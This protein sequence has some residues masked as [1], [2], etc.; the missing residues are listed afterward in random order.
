MKRL[1]MVLALALILVLG[2]WGQ[3]FP[4][5]CSEGPD[6]EGHPWGGEL[7]GEDPFRHRNS[8]S[9]ADYLASGILPIDLILKNSTYL[10]GLYDIFPKQEKIDRAY[11]S[12][13]RVA[14]DI[15]IRQVPCK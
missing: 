5:E 13:H 7:S 11:P 3:A 6:D 9:G 14:R 10:I 12:E 8:S 2:A 4:A 1:L 15:T